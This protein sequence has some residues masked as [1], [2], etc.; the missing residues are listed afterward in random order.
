MFNYIEDNDTDLAGTFPTHL[1]GL[2]STKSFI[3]MEVYV[4][5]KSIIVHFFHNILNLN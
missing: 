3:R 2:N 4:I 1:T 5:V